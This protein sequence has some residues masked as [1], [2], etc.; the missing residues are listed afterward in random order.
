MK[1]NRALSPHLSPRPSR[2]AL[3]LRG[4][5]ACGLIALLAAC[6]S[7]PPPAPAPRPQPVR[8][9]PTPPPPPPPAPVADW[10]DA[11]ITPGDWHW[12]REGAES[13]ARFGAPGNSRFVIRC[14]AANRT[15]S[16]DL[17]NPGA[18]QNVSMT[19]ITASQTRALWLQPRGAWLETVLNA[20]DPLLDAMAFSRG[21][22]AVKADGVTALYVPSWPEVSR[23]I[24][25]CRQ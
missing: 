9:A 4:A 15:I 5:L 20:R 22:F 19:L 17:P 3:R 13:V 18:S 2:P 10:R 24:E 8:P 1:A 11:P 16:L 21:R 23:V 6:A 14:A 25:D 12:A 7:T